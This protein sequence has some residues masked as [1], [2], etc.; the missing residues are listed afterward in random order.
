MAGARLGL[1]VL[2]AG[3]ADVGLVVAVVVTLGVAV[4]AGVL[5]GVGVMVAVGTISPS[6]PNTRSMTCPSLPNDPN[7]NSGKTLPTI[8]LYENDMA[9][10]K[11]PRVSTFSC[12]MRLI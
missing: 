5:V 8:T 7:E 6:L 12:R 4:T 9:S 1:G 11:I 2:I 3:R 10:I